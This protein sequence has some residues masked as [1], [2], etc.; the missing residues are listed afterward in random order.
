[1]IKKDCYFFGTLIK[2]HGISGKF[3]FKSD[4]KLSEE[5]YDLESVFIEIDEQL[6]PFFISHIYFKDDFSAIIKFEDVDS[7]TKA[8]EFIGCDLYL[9][10]D[11]RQKINGNESNFKEVVGFKVLD[12][13]YGEIGKVNKI[14]EIP[15]N[16]LI[17]IIK[18]NREILIPFNKEI[19]NY[20]D[21]KNNVIEIESPEGLI[22]IFR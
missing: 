6:V 3:I 18:D 16:P 13:K 14:L 20:V 11:N 12:V 5:Y 19:V 10:M 8:K 2:T 17:Q 15:N 9:P 4:K 7:D 1:M 22:D 21:K